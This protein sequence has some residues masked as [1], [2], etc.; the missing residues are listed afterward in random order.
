V[1][2]QA[3]H[4]NYVLGL[5]VRRTRAARAVLRDAL[6]QNARA[7]AVRAMSRLASSGAGDD[8]CRNSPDDLREVP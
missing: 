6:Q 3:L 4:P 8:H 7:D 1:E 2:R 5:D